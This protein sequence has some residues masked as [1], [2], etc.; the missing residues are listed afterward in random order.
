P[1]AA[2]AQ[3]TAQAESTCYTFETA[4]TTI[5]RF[6]CRWAF[7]PREFLDAVKDRPAVPDPQ[8]R[9]QVFLTLLTSIFMHAGW[10]HILGNMLFL[11]VF[12]DNVEDRL[13][14]L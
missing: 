6:Y 9:A 3:A 4:P 7:Q 5:D 13:G 8:P 14:H 10:L 1:A 2:R 11:W 12:G